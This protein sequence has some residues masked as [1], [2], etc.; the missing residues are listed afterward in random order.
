MQIPILRGRDVSDADNL[1]APG[2]V[3]INDFLARRY[4]PGE[5]AIGKRITFDDPAKNP[6]W[7]TVVGVVKNTARGSWVSPPAKEVFLPFLQNRPYLEIRRRHLVIYPGRAYGRRSRN[8][9]AR[10]PK[11]NSCAG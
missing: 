4:W 1:R 9:G 11:R 7:L 10:H 6:T 2:V 3:V 8:F 5:D